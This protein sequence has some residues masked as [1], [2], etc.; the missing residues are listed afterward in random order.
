MSGVYSNWVKVTHPNMSNNI[1]P[2]VSNG[3]QPSFFFGGSQIPS[4]LGIDDFEISGGGY[5]KV[6]INPD[7]IRGKV[8]QETNYRKHTNIHMPRNLKF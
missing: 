6:I 4:N 2:M 8:K 1:V 3:S 7:N 5:S